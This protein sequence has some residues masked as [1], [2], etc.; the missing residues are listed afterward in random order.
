MQWRSTFSTTST[1]SLNSNN[2]QWKS[3]SD[4]SNNVQWKSASCSSNNVQWKS[5]SA[6]SYPTAYSSISATSSS[7]GPFLVQT[8]HPKLENPNSETRNP[9]P[10]PFTPHPEIPLHLPSK[11]VNL[12]VGQVSSHLALR[13]TSLEADATY[14]FSVYGVTFL[15][16]KP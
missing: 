15:H 3:T 4:S 6:S 1:S 12:D 8:P 5:T 11:R 14:T 9:Q 13:G 10:S 7:A 2:V 16:L